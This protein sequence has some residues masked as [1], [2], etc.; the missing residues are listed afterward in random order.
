[1]KKF[2]ELS[3]RTQLLFLAILLTLPALVII[4]YSGLKERSADIEQAAIE[5][6]K[7][8]ENIAVA[9]EN[10]TKEALQFGKLIAG[11]PDVKKR[12]PIEVQYIL[13]NICK[14]NPQYLSIAITDRTGKA[15]TAAYPITNNL[16][17]ADRRYF[18]SAQYSLRFSSGEYALSKTT[19]K[20]T[21]TVG[22]PL[23]A[24]DGDF[25][26]VIALRFHPQNLWVTTGSGSF[27]SV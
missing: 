18:K 3:I 4:I 26:G 10:I 25:D 22:Y 7:L 1:M 14:D 8:A 17:F 19:G 16:S 9:Q 23:I 11:L 5:S 6:E 24:E 27:P 2:P 21:L 12:R 15:W 20:P 13:S